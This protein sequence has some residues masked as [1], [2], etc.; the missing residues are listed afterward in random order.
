M[1]HIHADED[2]GSSLF[3]RIMHRAAL[4]VTASRA[5]KS[6]NRLLMDHIKECVERTAGTARIL[7][8]ACGGAQEIYDFLCENPDVDAEFVL[9]DQDEGAL[10]FALERLRQSASELKR[11]FR[12]QTWNIALRDLIRS[13]SV[14]ERLDTFDLIYS[15]GLYDYLDDRVAKRLTTCLYN[16]SR[17]G[18]RVLL[19]NF[20]TSMDTRAFCEVLLEWFMI[21]RDRDAMLALASEITGARLRIEADGTGRNLFLVADRP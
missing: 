19:G 2:R 6:R 12:V 16:L 9:I 10:S 7:S 21:Y 20:D 4:E 14:A 3:A 11:D 8:L 15:A 5:V 18:G 17:P 13:R 1:D